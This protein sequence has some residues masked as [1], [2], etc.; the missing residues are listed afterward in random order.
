MGRCIDIPSYEAKDITEMF[1]GREEGNRGNSGELAVLP[2]RQICGGEKLEE[3]QGKETREL[4]ETAIGRKAMAPRPQL[5]CQP[6]L[7][8]PVPPLLVQPG[9]G[10]N[11]GSQQPTSYS[12]PWIFSTFCVGSERQWDAKTCLPLSL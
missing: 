6:L 5:L 3:G 8:I 9:Q 11:G 12:R 4:W 1:H 7:H 10:C 2:L